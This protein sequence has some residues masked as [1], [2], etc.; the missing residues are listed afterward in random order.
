MEVIN[1]LEV[2]NMLKGGLSTNEL[3]TAII[4]HILD[5][6]LPWEEKRAFWHL[7]FLS[8]REAT[9]AHALAQ[10]LKAKM[11]IPFD[12]IVQ[13]TSKSRLKPTPIVVEALLKGV[14]KQN[15]AEEMIGPT[16]WDHFDRRFQ[17]Q[18][19]DLLAKKVANQRA[20][21]DGLLEKFEYLQS[22]RM[23]EQAGRVLRRMVELYPDDP[24]FA[25]LKAEFEEQ[26]ARDVLSN[27]MATINNEKIEKLDRTLTVP[28]TSDEEMLNCFTKEG[29]KI[30]ML[31]REFAGDL[32][33]A[34]WFMED[35]T[36]ALDILAW[37]QPS[38]AC[39]WLK[40]E[41]LFSARR[42]IEALEWLNQLEIKYINDPETTFAVSYLRA[43]CLKGSG[44]F[45][46]ALEILQGIVRV[47]PNYRSVNTLLQEWTE[48][49]AWE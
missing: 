31:K 26:W 7:L 20:F 40:A 17:E 5:E 49:A 32:A 3:T 16:G 43:Q 38:L 2:R 45:T 30:C 6:S 18:R 47:R 36:R 39:D 12:L 23:T 27:H 8:G 48:G 41:L 33:I 9:L 14:R 1:E 35:Y 25:K 21:K 28:S 29:E 11:R 42:F 44:Q 19:E 22:Q 4:R 10:C 46:T 24:G 15:A 13:V 37:A 34:F